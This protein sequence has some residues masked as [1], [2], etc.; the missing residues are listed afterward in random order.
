MAAINSSREG[1]TEHDLP[2]AAAARSSPLSAPITEASV[3][4]KTYSVVQPSEQPLPLP[5]ALPSSPAMDK[6]ESH[7]LKFI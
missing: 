4:T 1:P 2:A 6:T 7:K 5:E 3:P